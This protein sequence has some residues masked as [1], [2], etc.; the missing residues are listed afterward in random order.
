MRAI[1]MSMAISLAAL[2]AAP[3]VA[4]DG[5]ATHTQVQ[6]LSGKGP[7]DAVPWQFKIHS[8]RRAG[9]AATIPVPSNWQQQGFGDY[10]YGYDKG[11]RVADTATYGKSFTVPADWKGRTVD[12]VFDGVMTDATVKVNGRL[13][14]PTH[15]GGF[16]RFRYDITRL[17]KF[18]EANEIELEVSEASSDTATDIAERHG[19]YWV[20]GGIYRPVWLEASP[21]ESASQVAI[22][23]KASG[24][25]T[26][27][28]TLRASNAIP[29]G[30]GMTTTRVT[31][32]ILDRDGKAVGGLVS[33]TLP[34]GGEPG[35]RLAG[36][37]ASPK[38][39]SAE[40]PNLYDLQVTLYA[41]DKIVHQ[42]RQRFGFRTFEVRD[43]QGLYLNGQ[44][45]MLKG[46]N[47]HSFRPDTGRAIGPKEAY[48]DVRLIKSMNMNAVRMSHYDPEKEF[49]EAADELGLYVL[50]ELSGWQNAH[51]TE[52]GRKL[53]RE[54]VE[55]DVDHPSILFWDNGNEGGWNRALDAEFWLYDPQHRTVLHPWDPFGGVDTK[56]YPRYDDLATRLA[57]PM[58][59][60]PTELLHALYDGG[61][62]AGLDDY[63]KAMQ[64]SPVGA[65]GFLWNLADE[66]VAR[67]DRGG[68]ID[69]YAAFAPDGL[70]G[71]RDEKEG[72]YY[73]VR[74]VWSP[75][76][77]AAPILAVGGSNSL[78]VKNDYDFTPLSEL[79]F[80]WEWITFPAPGA[81]TTEAR[82]LA[83]GEVKGPN[84]AP[85]TSGRLELPASGAARGADALR[86][87]ALRDKD[88]VVSWVWRTPATTADV[89]GPRVGA[90]TVQTE[91]GVIHLAA[92]AV[93]AD[94]D[95][96]TGLLRSVSKGGRVQ[97]LSGGKLVLA[98]PAG[99]AAPAWVDATAGEGGV[100]TLPTP[101]FA[102][103]AQI[104]LGTVEADG[105]N[106]FVLEISGDGRTWKKVYDGARVLPRDGQTY[107][108]PAQE[109]RAL[110]ISKLT[111]VRKTPHVVSVK[112]SGDPARYAA[113]NTAPVKITTG[114]GRDP[115][116]G[117]AVAWVDAANAGGLTTARWILRDDGE[118]LFDY[119]YALEGATLYHGVGFDQPAGVTRARALV[120]G[121]KP[122]WQNRM[123]G[124]IL[125]VYDIAGE[126][127]DLAT[128]QTAGYF[129]DPQW[130]RLTG[131]AT[132]DVASEGAGF[133]QV[134][135]RLG[136]FPTTSEEFPATSLG[137]LNA[138]PAMGAKSQPA[139]QTGPAGQ[140][141]QA[142]GVYAGRLRFR[143]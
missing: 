8:G 86:L 110:R 98:R 85:H 102:D 9:E 139:E 59:V 94:I 31:G 106:G 141:R 40:T 37:L 72:S 129:A 61:G 23:A 70:V 17:V 19:D 54:L 67:T 124:P 90:P 53:V 52:N 69:T 7:D 39:W 101:L 56:H 48:D 137:F 21:L 112:L 42:T 75:V 99:R 44:R 114:S 73:T 93:R 22:D 41:G 49:L 10:Q 130:V 81:A 95:A 1:L 46:V 92:G 103:V 36:R 108:F 34:H 115:A 83:S 138:I 96:S 97:A 32:Q 12:V 4:Q 104:D 131:A 91:G 15:Q 113:P 116:T 20:F 100:Y 117:R 142:N 14:G 58:L 51:A 29:R 127:P 74:E 135:A 3:A 38:L 128:P 57:G 27:D 77:V 16:N 43:G 33:V 28:I 126:G 25:W 80:R 76:Q 65:G 6:M 24:A 84:V 13:A 107:S 140:P 50:D 26:A 132:L 55:R 118:L 62:G 64:A 87:T 66:G 143:F 30:V 82:V 47:R 5:D 45:I 125:G 133:L 35:V 68:Q 60:M 136:D 122:V 120:R 63:W 89:P 71:P 11:P 18:G 78:T 2:V 79:R 119:S 109:V 111:G 105:W 134:G 123:R 121:P 88:A